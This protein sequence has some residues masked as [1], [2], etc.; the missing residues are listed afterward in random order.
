M[1]TFLRFSFSGLVTIRAEGTGRPVLPCLLVG[2]HLMTIRDFVELTSES[3]TKQCCT[4]SVSVKIRRKYRAVKTLA[5]KLVMAMSWFAGRKW[6][7]DSKCMPQGI[8]Y[9]VTA[10]ICT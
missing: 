6:K 7:N 5:S 4:A 1:K 2:T 9:C 10:I 3:Y 8:N